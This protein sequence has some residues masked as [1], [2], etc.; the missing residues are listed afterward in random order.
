MKKKFL[1]NSLAFAVISILS[2]FASANNEVT[3][4][5]NRANEVTALE[6]IVLT[7]EEQAKQA[8]GVSIITADELDKTP[9][10]NDISEIVVRMPRCTRK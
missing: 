3:E 6:K 2:G 8:L 5:E 1:T 10:S 9:V 4:H 7:A